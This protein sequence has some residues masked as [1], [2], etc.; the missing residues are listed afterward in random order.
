[1][2]NAA[3]ALKMAGSVLIF[4]IALSVCIMSFT[5][6]RQAVDSVVAF[7][8]REYLT[9]KN[10]DNFFYRAA[11]SAKGGV[12]DYLTRIVN[13]E[14]IIPA[15][16]R[17]YKEN[18]KIVFEFNDTSY[19][20]LFKQDF[21]YDLT[22]EKT[23]VI[24]LEKQ[25]IGSDKESRQFIDGILYHNYTDDYGSDGNIGNF[26]LDKYQSKFH[27]I[28]NGTSLY[29]YM[30][31]NNREIKEQL[32]TYYQEDLQERDENGNRKISTKEDKTEKRV[33]TYTFQ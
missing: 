3:E 30:S 24:D 26:S 27:I 21:D 7:S 18:Y 15:I 4:V 29:D 32:G 6:A 17:A 9:I 28:L 14:T 31:T 10:D 16:Y 19:D 20:F 33:I 2:E 12:D 1:M 11:A 25:I 5:Q 8:D 23:C 13:K 22:F